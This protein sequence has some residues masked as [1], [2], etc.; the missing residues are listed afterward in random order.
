MRKAERRLPLQPAYS[1]ACH[2]R[3]S[4][5]CVFRLHSA[6]PCCLHNRDGPEPAVHV[7][8]LLPNLCG[9]AYQEPFQSMLGFV[10][11][12]CYC[13]FYEG[14]MSILH[15]HPQCINFLPR[16]S[17]PSE[18]VRD[19]NIAK[20]ASFR[21]GNKGWRPELKHNA[22]GHQLKAQEGERHQHKCKWSLYL[23][24]QFFLHIHDSVIIQRFI[25]VR[26]FTLVLLLLDRKE[27]KEK[28][29]K[30]HAFT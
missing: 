14:W 23:P 24:R 10:P 1:L 30:L 4:L 19:D 15:A 2:K 17:E 3:G 12:L 22:L 5:E 25:Y 28:C 7:T 27:V 18:I 29:S 21:V 11:F 6:F 26:W 9:R 13:A 8:I 20:I 16:S